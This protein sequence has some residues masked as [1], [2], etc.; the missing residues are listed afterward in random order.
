MI[1]VTKL[2]SPVYISGPITG[3]PGGNKEGF[4][5]AEAY[6][7]ELGYECV[8]PR[9]LEIPFCL[10]VRPN[11]ELLWAWMMKRSLFEMMECNSVVLLEGWEGSKGATIEHQLAV[12]LGMPVAKLKRNE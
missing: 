12:I 5:D 9:H 2:K 10:K 3:I 11:Q 1:D 8:N 4:K 6:L 7:T